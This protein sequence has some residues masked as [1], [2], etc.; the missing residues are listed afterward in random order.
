MMVGG[1]DEIVELARDLGSSREVWQL[2][3]GFEVGQTPRTAFGNTFV[4][5][6]V[7]V[8]ADRQIVVPVLTKAGP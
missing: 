2:N 6:R 7:V 3:I 4:W 5:G 8:V 1:Q